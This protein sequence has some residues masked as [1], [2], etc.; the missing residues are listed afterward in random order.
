MSNTTTGGEAMIYLGKSQWPQLAQL[1]LA[2][3]PTP[4]P[5]CKPPLRPPQPSSIVLPRLFSCSSAP[6][7]LLF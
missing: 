6:L 3:A 5:H 7:R 2:A 4:E 1:G